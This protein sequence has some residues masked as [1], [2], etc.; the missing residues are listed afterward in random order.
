MSGIEPCPISSS[1]VGTLAAG[2]ESRCT[3]WRANFNEAYERLVLRGRFVESPAYYRQHRGR[4]RR[5]LAYYSAL[6]LPARAN[7]LEIGGGQIALLAHAV[8]NHRG[9][10]A[11]ISESYA[12]AVMCHGLPF[13]RC[14]LMRDC[15][16]SEPSYDCLVLCEVVEHLPVPLH[17]VLERI[18]PALKPG[19]S[20][21]VTT[22]NL[23]RLRNVM[24]LIRGREIFRPL[25][26][27]R[28]GQNLGH[29]LEFSAAHLQWQ[30]ERAGLEAVTIRL[31]QLSNY[32]S[33][34]ASQALRMLAAPLLYA[35]PLWRDN[36]VAW[37]RKPIGTGAG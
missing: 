6:P 28:P 4:F 8:M 1:E 30:L 15:L 36:L 11:D 31:A 18:L 33:S 29:V 23:H 32:G 24:R 10:V 14:D 26:Y 7:V 3:S 17:L 37:A 19:G 21:L 13:I 34:A 12:A 35:R 25:F 20:I 9:A 2:P 27:P 5:T 16:A 22:P